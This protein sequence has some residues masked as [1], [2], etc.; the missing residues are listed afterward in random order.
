MI[1][2][3]EVILSRLTSGVQ[4]G[5]ILL[6]HEGRDDGAGGRLAP[7]VLAKLLAWL[8]QHGYRCVLP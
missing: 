2:D 6:M 4:P 3:Q 5:A 8:R 7:Q 1:K